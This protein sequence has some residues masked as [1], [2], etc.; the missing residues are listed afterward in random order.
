MLKTFESLHS[1]PARAQQ[2]YL[3]LIALAATRSTI[4]YDVLAKQI[5]YPAGHMLAGPLGHIMKLCREY[6]LPALTSLVVDSQ[7]SPS[8]GLTSVKLEDVPG[9]QARVFEYSWFAH[10]PPSLEQLELFK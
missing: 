9:E 2:I 1:N 8:Q 4:K 7:G 3:I 6:D 5:G 10:V